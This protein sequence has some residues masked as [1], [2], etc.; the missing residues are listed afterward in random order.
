MVNAEGIRTMGRYA[1]D[2]RIDRRRLSKPNREPAHDATGAVQH[3]AAR[4]RR[5]VYSRW[6]HDE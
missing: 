6:R 3:T 4:R 2:M 5:W 1:D